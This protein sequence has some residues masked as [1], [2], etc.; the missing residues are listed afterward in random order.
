MSQHPTQEDPSQAQAATPGAV[1]RGLLRPGSLAFMVVLTGMAALAPLS[2]DMFLP[3]LPAIAA[4]LGATPARAQL[5]VTGFLGGFA[6]APL[7]LGPVSDQFGRR[8]V[9]IAG[10]AFYT[11]AGIAC[12]LAD[13]MTTLI[14]AR[15]VQGV[16][17]GTGPA[18]A[19]AI[20]RDVF[21]GSRAASAMAYMVTA[22]SLAPIL[23]PIIGGGLQAWFGW[24]SVFVVLTG[25]GLVFL[26][27]VAAGMPETVPW[28]DP[29]AASP[30]RLA[31]NYAHLLRDR[32]YLAY[33]ATV[34]L[35][36]G[37]LITFVSGS[38]YVLIELRGLP[39]HQ[40]GLSFGFVALG[41]T[42]GS[43]SAG[44]LTRRLGVDN[45]IRLGLCIG[46]LA[47]LTE[48]GLAWGGVE[49][50]WAI[51]LPQAC[52]AVSTG[53]T[54]PSAAAG[55][56]MPYPHMAGTA[57]ALHGFMQMGG[58]SIYATVVGLFH[59]GTALPMTTGIALGPVLALLAFI[60]L[61]PGS[62]GPVEQEGGQGEGGVR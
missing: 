6:L 45:L 14:A 53:M 37:G 3:S 12:L 5:A 48:A 41:L 29:T 19:R 9:L 24:P 43:F 11:L 42:L 39:S 22:V 61:M 30:R 31:A 8:P 47:G 50:I 33:M 35:L 28:R 51:L 40:F 56:I 23:A 10:F 36:F 20:V 15:V 27:A 60:L 4:E 32:R 49:S 57:S 25:L 21:T 54:M 2:I 62:R 18:L 1:R 46:C 52:F 26:G 16:A 55:A 34:V 17:A 13:S 7:V 38:S 44:R 58:A 59:D